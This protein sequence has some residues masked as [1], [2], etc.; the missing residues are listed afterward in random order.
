MNIQAI[1]EK[2][3][4]LYRKEPILVRAPGRVNLIGEHTDYNE[5]FV[6]PA[7][8]DKAII[9]AIA[10]STDPVSRLFAYDMDDSFEFKINGLQ[11]SNKGWPNYLM[12]VIDQFQKAG[13]K[14]DNFDC[15]FGGDIPIGAGMSSS[16]AIEAGFG[17]ALNEMFQLGIAKIDIVKMGQKAENEFVGVKCGIMDQFISVFGAEKKVL[18]LDC[19]SLN[20]EY[21]PFEFKDIHI[22]LCNTGV[23]HSLASS[24]YNIRRGQCE[25]GVTIIQKTN[26]GI[27]SLRDVSMEMLAAH[28]AELEPIIYQR[29]RYVIEENERLLNGCQDLQKGD[30]SAFGKKMY[31]THAGLRDDYG[32]SCKELDFLVDLA[33]TE[34]GIF[35]AR[36]MGGGFG[37]CT[38]N[39]IQEA[40]LTNF[41]T[42]ATEIYPQK[43]GRELK[44]YVTDIQ[45]G[46]SILS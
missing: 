6:L 28:R 8:I 7:A 24:E 40:A 21:F 11:K 4:S 27:R 12:G 23:S 31:A 38:I 22:L 39:L 41:I 17:S 33:S 1:K 32:V 46:V 44:V 42:K 29:C 13:Y 35:G 36:M 30:L 3:K 45:G 10:P 15:V 26:P 9:L 2:F 16:A 18:K 5:G 25:K 43:M 19:R 20:Y 37:G 34:P 14:I